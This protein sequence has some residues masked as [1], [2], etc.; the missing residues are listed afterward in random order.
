ME[1]WGIPFVNTVHD[2]FIDND[3][4]DNDIYDEDDNGNDK[5]DLCCV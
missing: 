3:N 1:P 4:N 5:S 2:L